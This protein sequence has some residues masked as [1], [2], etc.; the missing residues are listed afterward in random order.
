MLLLN[1]RL[2]ESYMREHPGVSIVVSGGGSAVGVAA[3]VAGNAEICAASRPLLAEE[4]QALHSRF[5]TLGV[6]FLVAQ[7][8]LSV[9]LN[10]T[11]PV[12][13]LS[14]DQLRR[15]FNGSTRSWSELGGDNVEV[16]VV[17]RPPSSGTYRYFRDHV[18]AG[19]G[20]S[21][22]AVTVATTSDVVAAVKARPG[23][24]G[25]GGV[26]YGEDVVHCAVEGVAPTAENVRDERYPL[27]RYLH[28]VTTEPPRGEVRRF[29]DWCQG[30]YGQQIVAEVGY[31]PLWRR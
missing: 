2:A 24:I 25:Y 1:R 7:D 20:Y 21:G 31:L 16:E 10:P 22:Q 6:R 28:L 19:E 26:A 3:L 11:N 30:R 4:I 29:I 9:Y 17:L 15:L 14:L 23:G 27:T 8:P 13:D 5:G 18:L 12:R